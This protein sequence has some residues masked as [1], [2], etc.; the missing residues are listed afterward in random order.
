MQ[1]N[2]T[3]LVI[4]SVITTGLCAVIAAYALVKLYGKTKVTSW[5]HYDTSYPDNDLAFDFNPLM[6]DN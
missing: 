2:N 3:S 5:Y 6:H 4:I 1:N